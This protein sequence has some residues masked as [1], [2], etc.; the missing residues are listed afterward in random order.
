MTN[1]LTLF[2][3][4]VVTTP[5]SRSHALRHPDDPETSRIVAEQLVASGHLAQQQQ[6]VL[7][8]LRQ[9]PDGGTHGELGEVMGCHWLIPARRL[10]E[11]VRLGLARRGEPRECRVKGTRCT[12][13]HAMEVSE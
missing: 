2:D 9:C 11:L 4:P 8:A 5:A 6:M 10:P 1:Q 13:W 12:V 7:E 3:V